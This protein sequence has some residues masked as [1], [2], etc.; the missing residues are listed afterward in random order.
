MKGLSWRYG[1]VSVSRVTT[2][3]LKQIDSGTLY[4]TSKRLLFNGVS[5]N[6]NV[7][8]KKIIQ[9]TLYK[10]GIQ[11][12]KDAGRDQYYL[13][14]ADLELLGAIL[15]ATIKKSHQGLGD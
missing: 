12:Q 10:D 9:F 14:S 15:E 7:P 3:E 6:L 13:G 11:I 2:E 5:K 4:V 1:Q 8:Y